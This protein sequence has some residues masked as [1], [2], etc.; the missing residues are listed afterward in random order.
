MLMN[1]NNTNNNAPSQLE[2]FIGRFSIEDLTAM[3]EYQGILY[4]YTSTKNINSILSAKNNKIILWASRYN[5]LNDITEGNL[6]KEIYSK[7]CESLKNKNQI[8]LNMPSVQRRRPLPAAEAGRSCW[9]RGQQDTNAAQ[10]MKW[11]LGAATL[12]EH[13]KSFNQR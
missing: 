8:S 4:H 12:G 3:P 13:S 5:C 10:G 9:G 1:A 7:A 6:I 2:K 11:M